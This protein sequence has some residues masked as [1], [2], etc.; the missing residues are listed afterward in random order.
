[1]NSKMRIL[2]PVLV[3]V[4]VAVAGDPAQA[5]LFGKKKAKYQRQEK[6]FKAWR[7]D[8]QPTMSFASGTMSRSSFTG[9][10]MD[11]V[12]VILKKD[13]VVIDADGEPTSLTEGKQVVVMGPRAGDTIIAWQIRV[14]KPSFR[15]SAAPSMQKNVER[16][17]VD[18]TV[19]V[20]TAPE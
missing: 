17:D 5:G 4:L 15:V 1:M 7:Y 12:Q 8:R 18:P 3:L 16:S 11:N 19:G 9:W 13:C 20:G 10:E 2:I 14:L 6:E